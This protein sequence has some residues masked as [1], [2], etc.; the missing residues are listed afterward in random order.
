M[1]RELERYQY[2]VEI[3]LESSSGRRDARISDISSGGCYVDTIVVA[4]EGED[5]SFELKDVAHQN[6][7]FTGTVAYV[8]DGMGFGIKFTNISEQHQAVIDRI[9]KSSGG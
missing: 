5:V 9:I 3:V 2:F 7:T 8:L 6:L 1:P 4:Q